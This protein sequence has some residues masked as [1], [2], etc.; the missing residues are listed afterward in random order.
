M[1]GYWLGAGIPGRWATQT[2]CVGRCADPPHCAG[3]PLDPSGLV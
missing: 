2:Q 3:T 1:T